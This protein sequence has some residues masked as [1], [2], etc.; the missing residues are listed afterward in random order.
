MSS[1]KIQSIDLF[2]YVG[3]LQL[4]SVEEKT[5]WREDQRFKDPIEA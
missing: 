3:C 5:N 4:A 2:F 1:G